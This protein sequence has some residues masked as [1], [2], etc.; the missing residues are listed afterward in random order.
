MADAKPPRLLAK[1][2]SDQVNCLQNA[3]GTW[4]ANSHGRSFQGTFHECQDWLRAN[5]RVLI[6]RS[7]QGKK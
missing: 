5:G 4:T 2:N 6:D 3:D 1:G 7:A